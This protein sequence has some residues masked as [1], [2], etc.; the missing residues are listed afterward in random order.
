MCVRA[1]RTLYT[2]LPTVSDLRD[3]SKQEQVK[4][5]GAY[6]EG[7]IRRRSSWEMRERPGVHERLPQEQTHVEM[8]KPLMYALMKRF[9]GIML[10]RRLTAIVT[11]SVWDTF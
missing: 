9:L 3:E 2:P 6:D 10:H 11:V 8:A 4:W 5:V 7:H 1:V